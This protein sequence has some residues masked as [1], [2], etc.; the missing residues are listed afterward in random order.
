MKKY[1][2]AIVFFKRYEGAMHQTIEFVAED[3]IEANKIVRANANAIAEIH[4]YDTFFVQS[5]EEIN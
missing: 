1:R 3:E 2:A 5:V 4:R